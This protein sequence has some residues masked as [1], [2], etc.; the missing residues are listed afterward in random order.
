MSAAGESSRVVLAFDVGGTQLRSALVDTGGVLL[1]RRARRTPVTSAEDLVAAL[2]AEAQ[3]HSRDCKQRGDRAPSA[4]GVA[5]AGYTDTARGLVHES[6]SLGLHRAEISAPLR[7]AT[8]LPVRLVNDVNAAAVAEAAALGSRDLVALFIGTGVG[9][10]FVCDGRLL[11]GHRGMAAEVGHAIW[12]PDGPPCNAGHAGCFQSFLGGAALAQRAA[13]A[14]LPGETAALVAA[15]RAGDPRAA[16]LMQDACD[17]LAALCKLLVTLL[18]PA[19][20]VL[21]GGVGRSVPEFLAVARAACDPH[22]L[23]PS[24]A[25]VTV[26]TSRLG[27]DAGLLGAA[28]LAQQAGPSVP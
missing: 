3:A 18:D 21:S 14:G 16:V 10:G 13:A 24:A 2:I 7:A 22:P 6:P 1:A 9:G 20:M 17:A 8:G 11:E 5:M 25:P 26:H 19:D 4:V 28:A 23:A 15:W 12:R 27:D